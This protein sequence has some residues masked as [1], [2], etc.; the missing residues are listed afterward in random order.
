MKTMKTIAMA[1]ALVA[2]VSTMA[3]AQSNPS[4]MSQSGNSTEQNAQSSGGPGTHVGAPKT[5][6][7]E[8]NA[9]VLKNQNGYK[10]DKQ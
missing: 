5:G 10:P 2:G 8:S 1:A 7:A 9:K 3:L 6:T 4:G